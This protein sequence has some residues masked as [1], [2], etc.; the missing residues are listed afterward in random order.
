MNGGRRNAQWWVVVLAVALSAAAYHFSTGLWTFWPAAWI[1][2][3]PILVVAARSSWRTAA[4]AFFAAY[5]LGGLGLVSYLGRVMPVPI[6][7]ALL[8]VWAAVFALVVLFARHAI[9]R[10]PSQW[11]AFAFPVAWTSVEFLIS[12]VS[13]HGTAQNFAYSQTDVL[14]L[15]QVASVTGVWG[16]SFLLTLVPSA[17]AVAWTRRAPSTLV[18][19]A[20]LTLLAL[21]FGGWRLRQLPAAA[22][23]RVG[24]AATDEGAGDAF[25]TEV[26]AE[27]LRVARSYAKR[28]VRLA[29]GGAQ[30]VV[31]PEKLV[32]I[33]SDDSADVL[34]VFEESAQSAS[35]ILVVGLNRIAVNPRRNLAVVFAPDGRVIAEYSKHHLLPGPETGYES[36]PSPGLFSGAGGQWGVAICKDMDFPA[37]LRG[38]GQSGVRILAVPAWDF[39]RDARLHSRMAIVRGVENGFAIARVAVQGSLTFSD[40]YGRILAE[41]SSAKKPDAL[42]VS[43]I[44]P[45]PGATF[46]TRRGDWFGWA[47]VVAL[48]A[49]LVAL[50]RYPATNRT[51]WKTATSEPSA[52]NAEAG[53]P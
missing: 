32:G 52:R 12:L 16:I 19:A 48:V 29:A 44:V 11:A 10:L 6:V 40:A 2:P 8:A 17:V 25:E 20:V 15:L 36:G 30:V 5:L 46:Y 31:L 9:R 47:T 39:V 34:K 42:L 26:P 28:V 43:E 23:V 7:V 37:W 24:L 45:G 21:G 38:Y 1:A 33:T 27:A 51:P 50:Q 4:L 14:P 13:P 18:P 49:M 53:G 3:V 35:V 22:A 41:D